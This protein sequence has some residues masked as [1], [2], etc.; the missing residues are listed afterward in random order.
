M[1]LAL[2]LNPK[3][4]VEWGGLLGVTLIVFA[5]TGLLVGFFLPGDSLLFTA[6]VIASPDNPFNF[7]LPVMPLLIFV[8]IA[9]IVGDTVGYWFGHHVGP[10]LFTRED[11]RLFH[12]RHLQR[13]QE[14]YERHG[15]K[16]IVLARFMPIVRTFA[17]VVAG[18]AKMPY[19]SFVA[20]NILG[21]LL[22]G[23]GITLA[24]YYLVTVI[25]KEGIEKYLY[26]LIAL[27]V[28]ISITPP[29]IEYLRQ[30]RRRRMS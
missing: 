3:E 23:A 30:R 25:G 16:T 26:P 8:C 27:I 6:G 19:R 4:L 24:G 29:L 22:W 18:A 7:S 1:A 21:G 20:Y 9:A 10:R 17:P 12:K 28:L 11:S 2:S 13:A 14:F 5:E 15:G